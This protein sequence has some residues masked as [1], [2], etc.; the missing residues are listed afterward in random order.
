MP[1][2]V[3]RCLSESR[4][5][6]LILV[7]AL[8]S[9]AHAAESGRTVPGEVRV[10]AAE[11]GQ[12]ETLTEL[13]A[14]TVT[15]QEAGPEVQPTFSSTS[16]LTGEQIEDLR[17][18]DVRSSLRLLPNVNS[19]PSNRGNNGITIRGINSEGVGEP[20]QNARP[21]SSL[22][23]DGATQSPEGM[24]R[25]VRGLWDVDSLEVYRGPQATLPGR[26]AIAGSV[27]INTRDPTP[28]WEG[29]AQVSAAQY[30]QRG[31][32][33]MLSGP[34][35]DDQLMF[36]VA[37]ERFEDEH[38]IT[39]PDP[40]LSHLGQGEYDAGRVKLLLRPRSVPGLSLKYTYVNSFD[41]PAITAVRQ[42]YS[43]RVSA[44]LTTNNLE[45]RKN[46][47]T[48]NVLDVG[49]DTGTGWGFNAVSSFISTKNNISPAV[50]NQLVQRNEQR[51]DSDFTQD[52]R[53]S[54]NSERWG[55]LGGVFYGSF[56]ND[57]DSLIQLAGLPSF[58]L[59]DLSRTTKITSLAGYGE[60]R[61]RP[62]PR[63]SLSAALRVESE[64]SKTETTYRMAALF[65]PL[66]PG[67]YSSRLEN[68]P[69]LF[70]TSLAYD[71]APT[72]TL[73]FTVS[74]GSRS[75]FIDPTYNKEVKPEHLTDYEIAYR[76]V[77]WGGKL[78]ANANLFWYDW[79]DQQVSL[80]NPT[81]QL[82]ETFNAQRS[83]VQGAELQLAL[84]PLPAL[85]MGVS[86]GYLSTRFDEFT[87]AYTTPAG[88]PPTPQ[89]YSGK[90]FPEAPAY[91]G[92]LWAIYRHPSGL[93][94]SGDLDYKSGFYAT[95]AI[96]NDPELWVPGYTLVNVRLGYEARH[97]SAILFCN[98]LFDRD[99]LTGRDRLGSAYVGDERVIGVTLNAY[100]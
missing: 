42:P 10:A 98:N 9:P 14:V 27:V 48:N 13:G 12:P 84:T 96:A 28:Y 3:H 34:V 75:G 87:F 100:F 5:L 69:V 59:Q 26:N 95:S 31:G 91:S 7:L 11:S 46:R 52:L 93:F 92:A 6:G 78:T 37:G 32:A 57:Q 49:Y 55:L 56:D 66:P 67:T 89:D 44:D 41:K 60:A 16:V 15:A 70:R 36:R 19:S 54:F 61:W 45:V 43:E 71:L 82:T 86:L 35:V 85:Q 23:I 62:R 63:L 8:A 90:E 68:S 72:H 81:T 33:V 53:A 40:S 25:G 88:I 58:P 47:V 22:V 24:R 4:E 74:G 20:G 51:D 29:A 64:T 38:N 76:G 83:T 30:N 39:Y 99:Y 18:R 80:I 94:L 1:R 77:A 65:H 2:R 73:A 17:V 21:L 79:T 50:S 97:W